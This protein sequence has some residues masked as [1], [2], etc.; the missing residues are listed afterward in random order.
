M[1]LFL[2]F[3][4]A[5]RALGKNKMRAG[6]TVLGVVIGIAAVT[7]MVSIGQSASGLVQGQFAALGTNVIVVLPG[8]RHRGGVRQAGFP[9]LTSRDSDAIARE[10]P[11]V[12]ASSP[13]VGTAGQVIC[14]NANWSPRELHGVGTDYLVVRNWPLRSGGFFTER[15]VTGA[16][17]VCVIGHTLVAK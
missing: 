17:K 6:L 2:T 15:D 16:A 8:S 12:L 5:L 13:L 7:A 14:G 3:R 10:C 4:V 9:T 1:D 11:A